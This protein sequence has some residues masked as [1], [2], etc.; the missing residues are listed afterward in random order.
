MRGERRKRCQMRKELKSEEK[1]MGRRYFLR[2]L[3][4]THPR[5]TGF[6]TKHR[7]ISSTKPK[8]LYGQKGRKEI[9]K[10]EDEEQLKVNCERKIT[11]FKKRSSLQCIGRR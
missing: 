4:L 5:R 7:T 10:A 1:G 6:S 2:E 9:K 8:G 3:D 11:S